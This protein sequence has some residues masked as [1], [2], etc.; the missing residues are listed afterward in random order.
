M[1]F[2]QFL[3]ILRARWKFSLGVLL[4]VILLALVVSLSLSKKYTATASIVVDIKPDPVSG[5]LLSSALT[6]SIIATQIDVI[7]SDRVAYRVVRNLKLNESPQIREQWMEATDG[8]GSIEQ[9]LSAVFRKSLDIRPSRESNVINVSYQAPDPKFAATLANA[10]VAAYLETNI[11]LRV[12]PAR[13]YTGFFDVRAKEARDSLEKAQSKLSEF[14]REKGIVANDER[15]DVES[16]R[17]NELSSQLVGLQA[18]AS[19]SGSRNA[20][21]RGS[22]DRLQE[23]LQNPVVA[24]LKADQAR[25]EARLQELQARL[26]DNHPQVQESKANIAELKRRIESETSKVTGSVSVNAS[27]NQ[28]RL[29]EL[30]GSLEAQR[31]KV[32]QMKAVRDEGSVL[33]RDVENAQRSYDLIMQRFNQMSLE[34]QATQSNVSVLTPADAPTQPTSPNLVLNMALGVFVGTLLAVAVVI[35]MELLDRRVRG[36]EDLVQS[37]GL[38][39]IG[40]VPGP[41]AKRLFGRMTKANLLQQ[42]LVA[43]LPASNR[44]N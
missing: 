6:P 10:F 24:G 30:R 44:G 31:N 27:I 35:V 29:A 25:T 7:Q 36:V 15:L 39:I 43:Q 40:V 9:W 11:E 41:T 1:S 33:L 16:A 42:R 19:E 13:Q 22:A 12:E 8:Q 26:G 14:Q 3:S 18:V 28:Q 4:G 20:A 34:S 2:S 32:L 21:A 38:P 5:M 17:L 37:V 23:V